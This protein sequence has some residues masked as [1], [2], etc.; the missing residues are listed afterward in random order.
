MAIEF[1][2]EIDAIDLRLLRRLVADGRATWADLAVETDMT[3]PGVAQRVRRLRERGV[4]RGFAALIAPQ[5]VA[6]ICAFV[7][8]AL[9]GS[10]GHAAFRDAMRAMPEAQECHHVAG[11]A[12]YLVKLRCRSLEHLEELLGERLPALAG[13]RT[14]RTTVVVAT[15][16]EEPL[17]PSEEEMPD[18]DADAHSRA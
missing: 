7:S 3:A 15:V 4:L 6:P 9:E 5:A 8:V 11:D 12:D 17:T 10:R 2:Y 1:G 16:K 13:V 14:A 18:A